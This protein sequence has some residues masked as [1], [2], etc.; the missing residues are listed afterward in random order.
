MRWIIDDIKQ[1]QQY[2]VDA[3]LSGRAMPVSTMVNVYGGHAYGPVQW[4]NPYY[5]KRTD[6]YGGSV[7]NRGRF[8][9]ETLEKVK[10]AVGHDCAIASRF[11]IDTLYGRGGVEVEEDGL[12]LIE[13][14][15]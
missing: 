4:L 6:E 1:V 15:R 12:K 7:E 11:A 13:D 14:G 10:N 3:A 5:N 8:W 9:V 2:Y